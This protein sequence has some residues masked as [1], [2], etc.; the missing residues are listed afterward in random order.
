MKT[1]VSNIT[2]EAEVAGYSLAVQE[3]TISLGV[4]SIPSVELMCAPSEA[5]YAYGGPTAVKPTI[6]EYSDMYKDLSLLAEGL[7]STGHV[8]IQVKGDDN[9]SCLLN[10]WI[11]TGVGM[12]NVSSTQAPY[13]SV[14]LQHPICELTKVGSIYETPKAD[15]G[16]GLRDVIS[17]SK[18]RSL[19]GIV[20]AAYDYM[21]KADPMFWDP[22]AGFKMGPKF[23]HALPEYKP[24][25]YLEWKGPDELFLTAGESG[26][27]DR[28][29][30]AIGNIVFPDDGGTSTWDMIV[31]ASGS[32]L[33]SITQ[34]ESNN[35]TTDK[36]VI[37]PTQ[38]W[39]TASLTIDDERCNWV[40]LP[41]MNPLRIIGVMARKL[42]PYAGMPNLGYLPNGNPITDEPTSEVMYAP[43][44][45]VD[46]SDG[47]IMKT[48]TPNMLE[49]AF[50]MD[51][52]SGDDIATAGI[53]MS[54]GLKD[55]FNTAIGKYC[56]AVYEITA[57][58][59][60]RAK[61]QMAVSFHSGG[62]LLLP[63]NTCVFRSE[64]KE[65]FYGYITNVV[66]NVSVGGGNST[67][68]V[69]SYVRPEASFK[70]KGQ[71]AIKAGSP[72]AAYE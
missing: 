26:M 33:L 24:S 70:I 65:I 19:I 66:H 46:V 62:K 53:D 13:L 25:K 63:G 12:S 5:N 27:K 40:E 47:R 39:K 64:G 8:D 36:L 18:P 42:G 9:D 49:A 54:A 72:N 68:V 48:N 44:E 67:T 37:E 34:D 69:M 29:A 10:R 55:D 45:E 56:K 58:S 1:N 17:K 30:Q 2:V 59:M 41:G 51:A 4:N 38:P 23:R 7:D 21:G 31:K 50:R 6:S 61:A 20:D 71:E 52:P 22:P 43:I 16:Q 32:L 35:Y 15:S 3:A 57:A 14:I 60:V 28:M 11:L